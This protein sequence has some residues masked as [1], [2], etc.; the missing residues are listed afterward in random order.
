V[1][2]TLGFVLLACLFLWELV[3]MSGV[4]VARDMQMFFIPQRHLLWTAFQDGRLPQWTPY[5]GSGTP[6]LANF[7]TG[8]FYPPHWLFAVLP[9][10]LTFN[11]L[12]VLH[13]AIGGAGA[14]LMSRKLDLS[15]AGSVAV[16]LTFMLGGYFVSL[17]TLLNVLQTAAWVP[18]IAWSCLHHMERR[19]LVSFALVVGLF[20]L[21]FLAGE[22]QTF[23]LGS[24]FAALLLFV[25]WPV[26]EEPGAGLRLAGT[27]ALAAIVVVG[28]AMA[29]LLPTIELLSQSSRGGGGLSLEESAYFSLPPIRL[30]NLLIPADYHDP[31]YRYGV[32]AIIGSSPPWL[33][34]IYV[35]ALAPI[36]AVFAWALRARRRETVLA[37]GLFLLG[38]LLSLGEHTPLYPWLYDSLPG[39]SAFRFP[40]KYFLFCGL[41][42]A[43]LAGIGLDGMR[44][45]PWRRGHV[46]LGLLPLAG[47]IGARIYVSVQMETVLD[48]MSRYF[49]NAGA[50]DS[51]DFA[52][53][54]WVGNLSKL[55][56]LW[57]VGLVVIGL[58]RRGNLSWP[59]CAGA[60]LAL[61]TAD[62]AAAHRTLNPTVEPEFYEVEP[63]VARFFSL[64]E[65]RTN[66]RFRA[67]PFD[68]RAGVVQVRADIALEAQKWMWQQTLQPNTGQLH[69]VLQIDSWDAIKLQRLKDRRNLYAI[70]PDEVRRWLLLRLSSVKYAYFNDQPGSAPSF[71]RRLPMDSLPGHLY[72][73]SHPLP[74]AYVVS[75]WRTYRDDEA[76]LNGMLSPTFDPH[77]E[78]VLLGNG[79]SRPGVEAS[80]S[81]PDMEAGGDESGQGRERARIMSDTGEEIRI[82]VDVDRA[83]F[84][85]L[86]DTFYPGW[87]ATVD[88]QVRDIRLANYF[89]RAVPIRPGDREVVFR[90]RSLPLERGA[91]ISL[92]TL[93]L[94]GVGLGLFASRRRAPVRRQGNL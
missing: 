24:S 4:P 17:L 73:I 66:Y 71:A 18:L 94:G 26:R 51:L 40:E 50:L 70:L 7:Q 28:L 15:R 92:A 55:I 5:I 56:I 38:L 6:L 9:F 86:T 74:R 48:V 47:L 60:M 79:T 59:V 45:G 75:H 25:R 34:S 14:Y 62:L 64:D 89:F 67:T 22:P 13:F 31:V 85:V 44:G 93:V 68:D 33:F 1:W 84:L 35:G 90:Y 77:R 83:G 30:V 72:Q 42:A 57:A 41:G 53:D 49:W 8:V 58:F 88:G 2:I 23:L 46:W 12:V 65:V 91:M 87:Q 20:L 21:A 29:Q 54:I 63:R 27:F 82:G 52:Y 69:G 3:R 32:K 78:V 10:F 76:A 80:D 43:L 16:G 11:L 36:L 37:T 81:L 61:M 19:E 39:F